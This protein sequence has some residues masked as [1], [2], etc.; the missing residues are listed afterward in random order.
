MRI[1]PPEKLEVSSI[2]L[3]AECDLSHRIVDLPI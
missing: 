1:C 2:F 3:I